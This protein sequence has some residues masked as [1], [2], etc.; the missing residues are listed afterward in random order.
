SSPCAND[1]DSIYERLNRLCPTVATEYASVGGMVDDGMQAHDLLA[2]LNLS[3]QVDLVLAN[4]RL[5]DLLMLWIGHNNVTWPYPDDATAGQDVEARMRDKAANFRNLY[6]RQLGRL[7]DKAQGDGHRMA[8]VV[9]GVVNFDSFFRA[10]RAA[11][12]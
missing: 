7:I 12:D 6:A 8:I 9:F 4:R 1:I 10:R 3:D 11:E 5:P 2:P